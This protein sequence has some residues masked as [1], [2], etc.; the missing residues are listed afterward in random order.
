MTV[1]ID[2]RKETD[3]QL[4]ARMREGDVSAFEVIVERHRAALIVRANARLGSFADAE[5]VAQEAFVQ[6]YLHIGKL[7]NADALMPWLRRIT[8]RLSLMRIRADRE[9]ALA[10]EVIEFVAGKRRDGLEQ[11]DTWAV[12]Q[13]LAQLPETM[14]EAMSLTFLAGYTCAEAAEIMGVKEGTVKTRLSR[15]RA[16]LKE[17]LVMTD[18]DIAG[19]RPS[20]A[21]TRRTIERLKREA[22]RLLAS[23]DVSEASKRAWTVLNEQVKPL[24]GDPQELG[25]AKTMLAAFDSAAF[26]PDEEA[27]AMLGLHRK[28]QRRKEC[29]ANAAH[30]GFQLADLDWEVADVNAMT[31][32]LGRPTGHGRDIWGVPVSRRKLDIIDA[33]ALCQKLRVSPLVLY[34]WVKD[35][36][37]ILRCWPF[38]RFDVERVEDWLAEKGISDWQVENEYN[39]ERPIRVI[40]TAVYEGLISA[41][42]AEDVMGYL[43][44]G[45]WSA[46]MPS[47]K[48]GW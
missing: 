2:T 8:D 47:L 4:V 23:G 38:A 34:V 48:G 19:G 6:A 46:P 36:C 22:H 16:K 1:S 39:L 45:V 10:P 9:Q 30:Y 7:R 31:E 43:G 41:E 27:V 40:F 29:E 13:L 28:E 21:F 44:Y 24:F 20:G 42:Q 17:A 33:R 32:T 35:G 5:D 18:R 25:L 15:A 11:T 3:A 14:R 12:E 26:K 37:P